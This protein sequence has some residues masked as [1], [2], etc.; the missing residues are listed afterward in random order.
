MMPVQNSESFASRPADSASLRQEV[1]NRYLAY[2]LSTIV[3]R[4]LPDVRDGLKP[5]HRRILYAMHAM[6]L[7]DSAKMRKSAAVVGEVIGK[8]HPHGDQ[9]A[10]DALVRMAQDFSLRYPLVDGSGNFGSVDGDSPA[11][12]RYTETRLSGFA[13]LLLRDIDQGTTE[14]RATY[15]A[16]GEEPLVLPA[17]VPNLLLNGS[18]GIAVGMSCSFPPHNLVEVIA[19]CRA[20]IRDPNLN[21]KGLLKYVKG[22]DFPTQGEILDGPAALEE[23]Y[24]SGHGSIRLRASYTVETSGRGRT[25]LIVTSIPYSVNKSRLIERIALL[26]K[27]KRLKYVQDVRDESTADVR[28]VLEQKG[29]DVRPESVMAFLYKHTDLQ[30]NFP[31]NFIA[32]TPQGVPERLGL[33]GIIRYFLDFR[34]ERTVLWLQYRL[35]ILR[36]RIHVLEGFDI[37][38]RDLDRALRIIRSSRS[39]QEAEQGLKAAFPLDDEQ[40][41]AILETRLYRLVGMEI[42]KVLDELA[43]KKKEAKEVSA[44]LASP[45]RLWKIID[46]ELG[47]VATK[48]GD[49]RR[50]CFITDTDAPVLEYDPEEFVEHEDSTVILSRQGWI[51]RLKSEVDDPSALKFREGDGLFACVRVNTGRTVAIFSNLGKIYVSRVIDVPATTGFGEPIGSLFNLGDGEFVVGFLAPDPVESKGAGGPATE[52]PERKPADDLSEFDQPSLFDASEHQEQTEAPTCALPSRG[53]LVTREGQGFRFDYGILRE[54]SKRVG[55]KLAHLRENDE[56]VSVRAEEGALVALGTDTG[57]V[58]VFPVDQ[59]PVLSGPGQGVRMIRLKGESRVVA[60]E[61]VNPEDVL[62]IVSKRGKER[63]VPVSEL[64]VANRGGQGKAIVKALA[65]MER[66]TGGQG[67]DE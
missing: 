3:A 60:L 9:A 44:D 31:I 61:L 29:S 25:N 28:I 16:M 21:T 56:T 27:D 8:Y 46:S 12:M 65:G 64:A 40:V 7:G 33:A 43:A 50:T 15:D 4:A 23:V 20:A 11:A 67:Q 5:V 51:H 47:Q 10:Y 35:E 42:G 24:A 45:E 17:A 63:I 2:A 55:R 18:S 36:K 22:P 26:I 54:P 19:A 14:F 58:L 34:Y 13:G 57:N 38:F 49:R 6:H 48:F 32:I 52:E 39:R 41:E 62:R 53:I 37:L 59:A 1:E 66:M 30:I